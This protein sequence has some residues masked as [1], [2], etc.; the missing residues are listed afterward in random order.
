MSAI[1]PINIMGEAAIASDVA[2]PCVKACKINAETNLCSGC[3]RTLD[4]IIVWSKASNATKVAIWAKIEE[5][6]KL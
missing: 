4:E 3:L 5:R 1:E 6:K 2:S